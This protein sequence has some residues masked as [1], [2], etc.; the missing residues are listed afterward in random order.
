VV[1]AA[2]HGLRVGVMKTVEGA[3]CGDV[4]P[5][6]CAATD[7]TR[8]V[9]VEAALL[10]RHDARPDVAGAIAAAAND[11]AVRAASAVAAATSV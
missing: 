6:P 9:A 2:D 4:H 10:R 7:A 8:T 3:E 11:D 5:R 1:A